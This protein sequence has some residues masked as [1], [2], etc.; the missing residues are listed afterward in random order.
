MQSYTEICTGCTEMY[1]Y[2]H[3]RLYRVKMKFIAI[4]KFTRV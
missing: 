4:L 1:A 2:L 3:W